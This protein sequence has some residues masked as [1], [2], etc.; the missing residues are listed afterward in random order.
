MPVEVGWLI[1]ERILYSRSWDDVDLDLVQRH[2]DCILDFLNSGHTTLVYL[3]IDSLAVTSFDVELQKLN[4]QSRRYLTHKRLVCSID[5]TESTKN[6]VIGHVV[7]GI[8]GVHWKY[9]ATLDEALQYIILLDN[10]FDD[11][12]T[13]LFDNHIPEKTI[14]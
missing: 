11:L 5:V 3:I 2:A 4:L 13:S 7:S 1:T 14:E 12:D 10:N 6:Q 9:V 8:A